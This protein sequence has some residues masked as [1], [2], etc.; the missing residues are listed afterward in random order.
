[1]PDG[2]TTYFK[3]RAE[4]R[5]KEKEAEEIHRRERR[6]LYQQGLVAGRAQAAYR[7]GLIEGR[8]QE[9]PR[10]GGSGVLGFLEGLGEGANRM[11]K[12]LFPEAAAG[13]MPAFGAGLFPEQQPRTRTHHKKKKRS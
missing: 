7:R 12:A 4:E 9:A 6:A 10:K 11:E 13:G 2:I 3:K 8:Q 5:R 1:M